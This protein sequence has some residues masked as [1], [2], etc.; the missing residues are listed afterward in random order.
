MLHLLQGF[1]NEG[2]QAV[3]H[4]WRFMTARAGCS[5]TK[6]DSFFSSAPGRTRDIK[7]CLGE[8]EQKVKL[9]GQ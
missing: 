3:V 2:A 4:S 1:C 6:G 5:S 9:N 7:A 8:A